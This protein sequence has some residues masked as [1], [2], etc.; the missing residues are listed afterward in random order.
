VHIALTSHPCSQCAA[1]L[2]GGEPKRTV[3]PFFLPRTDLPPAAV[4]PRG[5]T[6]ILK[7]HSGA[8]IL[9]PYILQTYMTARA[10]CP[11]KC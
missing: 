2:G 4:L 3:L 10:T 11:K 5:S 6:F 8:L 1:A 7:D 9:A